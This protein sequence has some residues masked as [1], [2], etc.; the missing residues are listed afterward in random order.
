MFLPVISNLQDQHEINSGEKCIE[1]STLYGK[2]LMSFIDKLVETENVRNSS[3]SH[4]ENSS[5]ETSTLPK[6]HLGSYKVPK[7]ELKIKPLV[8]KSSK[9]EGCAQKQPKWKCKGMDKNA[10]IVT[11]TKNISASQ[12]SEI[13]SNMKSKPSCTP[14]S[15]LQAITYHVQKLEF[16]ARQYEEERNFDIDVVAAEIKS[17][18]LVSEGLTKYCDRLLSIRQKSRKW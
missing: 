15:A 18:H 13:I 17:V 1:H 4:K 3:K 14:S 12:D 16:T 6:K 8:G 5:N 10:N 2:E 11:K 9:A 7:F